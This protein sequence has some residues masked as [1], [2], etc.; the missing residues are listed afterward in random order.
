MPGWVRLGARRCVHDGYMRGAGARVTTSA[1]CQRVR[2]GSMCAASASAVR[3]HG[4]AARRTDNE[5]ALARSWRRMSQ[6]RE[7][8]HEP[9]RSEVAVGAARD[10]DAG[11]ALPE[12]M[13]GFGSDRCWHGRRER[14]ARSG[15]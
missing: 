10:V 8:L 9:K 7:D 1:L 12:C 3:K 13:H 6:R 4:N 15:E 5:R 2:N 14:S 11:H